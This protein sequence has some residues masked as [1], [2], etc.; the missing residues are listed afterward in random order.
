MFMKAESS[1]SVKMEERFWHERIAEKVEEW[2]GQKVA[3]YNG[4]VIV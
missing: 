1:I 4:V 3:S 2:L